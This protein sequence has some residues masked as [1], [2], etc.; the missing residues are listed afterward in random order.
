MAADSGKKGAS[1]TTKRLKKTADG[2]GAV[3]QPSKQDGQGTA[4][5]RLQE[6]EQRALLPCV[7]AEL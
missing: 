7:Q 6:S 1:M 5:R 4:Q 3:P 2:D